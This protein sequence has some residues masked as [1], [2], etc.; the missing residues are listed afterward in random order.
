[1]IVAGMA[2]ILCAVIVGK[3]QT[4]I[5]LNRKTHTIA[6]SGL[7]FVSLVNSAKKVDIIP[8]LILYAKTNKPNTIIRFL[9]FVKQAVLNNL[10]LLV[11]NAI[12]F[13]GLIKT[14]FKMRL[15]MAACLSIA[16]S[17]ICMALRNKISDNKIVRMPK[18]TIHISPR[19]KSALYDYCSSSFLQGAILCD[20]FFVFLMS[21]LT[22][23]MNAF[24][25]MEDKSIFFFE[26][27]LLTAFGFI[28]IID[29]IPKMNWKFY[30]IVF[31][32]AIGY[33]IKRTCVFLTVFFSPFIVSFIFVVIVFDFKALI[34]YMYA[35]VSL[36]FFSIN[37]SFSTGSMLAKAI[38]ALIVTALTVW[39]CNTN[40]YFLALSIVP[41]GVSFL[42]AKNEYA[43]WYLL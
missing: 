39:V 3:P 43:D 35:I 13:K 14:E 30:A 37:V 24:N 32:D 15:P 41:V 12:V 33:H 42:K 22:R 10:L 25:K 26:L 40:P 5:V 20:A 21:E 28:G 34:Q 18:K 19:I 16:L 9:F 27:L 31:P 2:I 8:A 4:E 36:L 38:A 1:V 29:S 7:I 23:D 17:L 11:F 6:L